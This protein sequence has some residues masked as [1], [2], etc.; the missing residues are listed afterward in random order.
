M[1]DCRTVR[2]EEDMLEKSGQDAKDW[3]GKS[4]AFYLKNGK[5]AALAE[6]SKR[7]GLFTQGEMYVL[8]LNRRGVILAHGVD[9]KFI[10]EDSTSIKDYSGRRFI[11]DIIE[12]A[13]SEGSGFVEYTWRDPVTHDILPKRLY[14]Q[15]V[16][17]LI[18]CS[19]VYRR[20]WEDRDYFAWM[21]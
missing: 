15:K 5:A 2:E 20:M 12:T 3:V 1:S 9:E 4:M 14:F 19:G 10:G 16:D 13:N 8:V 6:F 18:I 7:D 11:E 21:P 17:N